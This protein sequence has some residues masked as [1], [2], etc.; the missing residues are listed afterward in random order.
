MGSPVKVGKMCEPF[1]IGGNVVR[2]MNVFTGPADYTTGG[3]D[4]SANDL[5]L[6][7]IYKATARCISGDR[8]T[9]TIF[10]A[11]EPMKTVK[12]LITDLAGTEVALHSNQSGK[13]FVIEAEGTY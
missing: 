10:A 8:S 11:A 4:L 9:Q 2:T 6:S 7:W 13:K 12:L 3:D 1:A 5:G